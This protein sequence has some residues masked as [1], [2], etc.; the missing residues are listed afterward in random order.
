M[1]PH[2]PLTYTGEAACSFP[3][4]RFPKG[5]AVRGEGWQQAALS[6]EE[7]PAHWFSA[8]SSTPV[9]M[10]AI[11]TERTAENVKARL[12]L[13]VMNLT[14]HIYYLLHCRAFLFPFRETFRSTIISLL[15][16]TYVIFFS[17]GFNFMKNL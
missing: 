15:R 3:T 13:M 11:I 2:Y 4:D 9:N 8:R 17:G 5:E 14:F 10:F 6:V 12:L 16:A 7:G 1:D